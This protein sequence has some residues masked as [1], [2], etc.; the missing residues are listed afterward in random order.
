MLFLFKLINI[1][2]CLSAN[3]II[4][5]IIDQ[6]IEFQLSGIFVPDPS[7]VYPAS[8]PIIAG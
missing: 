5:E 4:F 8:H 7:R 2:V 6:S 1:I 3:Q